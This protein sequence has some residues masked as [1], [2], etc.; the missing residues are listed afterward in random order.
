MLET[1]FGLL[2][3]DSRGAPDRGGQ[4]G[5]DRDHRNPSGRRWPSPRWWVKCVNQRDPS[6]LPWEGGTRT[7]LAF[8]I[9]TLILLLS[10]SFAHSL[11]FSVSLCLT[12]FLRSR[13][14]KPCSPGWRLFHPG[15]IPRTMVPVP[16]ALSTLRGLQILSTLGTPSVDL[17]F[18]PAASGPWVWRTVNWGYVSLWLTQTDQ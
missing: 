12:F 7:F 1:R 13:I 2:L 10:L 18:P 8:N 16:V 17:P 6:L 9:I 14:T 11:S 4:W 3:V 15:F 5:P